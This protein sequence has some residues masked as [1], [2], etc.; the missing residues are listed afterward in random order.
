MENDD[1][2][3]LVDEEV[4]AFN[5]KINFWLKNFQED[6]SCARSERSHSKGSSKKSVK[7]NM[8]KTSGSS[9][10][11]S[12]SK[13]RALKEKVQFLE[14]KAE[15]ALLVRRQMADIDAENVKIQQMVAKARARTKIFEE[16]EV[17]N[18]FLHRD[19]ENP[20]KQKFVGSSQDSHRTSTGINLNQRS[21]PTTKYQRNVTNNILSKDQYVTEILH[22]L[23][24]K[25]LM[26]SVRTYR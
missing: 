10:I 7:S 18:K 12:A 1:W 5:R 23:V 14:V 8:T 2:I 25:R 22:K 21:K 9:S 6:Q 3:D 13:T 16:P 4:F 26:A 17:D 24:N 15:E 20:H 19:T 11:S